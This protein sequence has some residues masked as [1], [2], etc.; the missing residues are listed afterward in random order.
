MLAVGIESIYVTPAAAFGPAAA[1]A[2]TAMAFGFL[3]EGLARA[4][5]PRLWTAQ[6]TSRR[7]RRVGTELALP[8]GGGTILRNIGNVPPDDIL[9]S[10]RPGAGPPVLDVDRLVVEF[11]GP[12]GPIRILDRVS[13]SINQGEIVGVVGESGSGKTMTALAVARLVPYPG[14]VT[15]KVRLLGTEVGPDIG[16]RS[17]DRALERGLAMVFQDPMGSFNPTLHVGTQMGLPLRVHAGASRREAKRTM[18]EA[19][20]DVAIADPERQLGRY[21]HEFSGGM[22]QRAM[23]AKALMKNAPLLICDEPTTALDVTIQAQ[24]ISLLCELNAKQRTTIL[25][26]SHNIALVSQTCN[27]ILVMYAGRVVEE[28][29]AND[30]VAGRVLH[31]YTEALVHAVPTIDHPRDVP[32]RAIPGDVPDIKELPTGCPYHPRCPLALDICSIEMPLLL[33]RRD[34]QRVACHVANAQLAAESQQ[35]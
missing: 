16:R 11:P 1:I 14:K 18:A 27:R 13:F 23:I 29:T 32:L 10:D 35:S 19:L 17:A 22:L 25:L 30:L 34:D 9:A 24:I 6:A 31:P 7:K 12:D 28:L 15:G 2:L 33:S 21:P 26:I 8:F 20:Q 3:G 5:N 4:M